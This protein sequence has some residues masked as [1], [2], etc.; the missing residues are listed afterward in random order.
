ME[1]SYKKQPQCRFYAVLDIRE[2]T[3]DETNPIFLSKP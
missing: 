1:R 2:N 3:L